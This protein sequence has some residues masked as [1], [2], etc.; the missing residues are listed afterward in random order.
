[1]LVCLAPVS[2]AAQD[3][4]A[5]LMASLAHRDNREAFFIEER[6]ASY[7]N[8]ALTT[9]G[10][11]K[12]VL[13]D[14]LEKIIVSP[15]PMTQVIT[16]NRLIQSRHGVIQ[17]EISLD[18]VPALSVT[19]NTLRAVVFGNLNYL[20]KTFTAEYQ[21][22]GQNWSLQLIPLNEKLKAQISS[23]KVLG[24]Q[25]K[26]SEFL[27]TDVNGDFSKTRLYEHENK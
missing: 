7:L 8:S 2:P 15:E 24:K 25:D 27:V 3:T 14:R 21:T 17:K 13:P 22:Q 9:Q 16:G 20:K 5:I 10:R 6:H 18:R 23:I 19:I 12:A 1:M 11:L 26:I 4:L